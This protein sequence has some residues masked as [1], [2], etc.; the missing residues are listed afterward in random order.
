MDVTGFAEYRWLAVK[1]S[2]GVTLKEL[3]S[4][5]EIASVLAQVDGPSREAK[6]NFRLLVCWFKKNWNRLVPWMACIHLR[7]RELRVIDG[8]R[9]LMETGKRTFPLSA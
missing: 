1:F 4:V 6:R 2:S 5:A 8:T 3:S 7:D 9:E